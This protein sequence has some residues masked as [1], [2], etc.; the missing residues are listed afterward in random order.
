LLEER[1]SV[2]NLPLILE[3]IAEARPGAPGAE[4]ICEHVRQRLGFQLVADLKR[5]DGTIPLIQLAP[6]WEQTFASYQI[7]GPRGET[8]VA[9]P[10]AEFSRLAAA[11]AEKFAHAAENGQA[12]ALVTSAARR[13]FLK[14][15]LSAKGLSAPVLSYEEI[16]LDARPALVGLVAA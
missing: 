7:D 10:P 1:V 2:R 14:M 8:D 4:A 11:L 3:A 5:G 15:V 12:A 16:G 13:R 9:L 6:E